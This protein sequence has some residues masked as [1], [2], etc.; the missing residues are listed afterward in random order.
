MKLSVRSLTITAALLWALTF[1]FVS[2]INY[3]WPSYGRDFLEIVSSLYP[4]YKAVG[5]P[6]SIIVGTL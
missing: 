6:S 5:S 1:L 4:G 3:V 2:V